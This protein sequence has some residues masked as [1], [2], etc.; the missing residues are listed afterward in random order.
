M[1]IVLNLPAQLNWVE[2]V[3]SG[4]L[5][6]HYFVNKDLLP[7]GVT[8]LLD[9]LKFIHDNMEYLKD[10]N[11]YKC[12]VSLNQRPWDEVVKD[13]LLFFLLSNN[14]VREAL[15]KYFNVRDDWQK[16][17]NTSQTSQ[18]K[19]EDW[20]RIS[21]ALQKKVKD[22]DEALGQ[23]VTYALQTP[24]IQECLTIVKNIVVDEESAREASI[25]LYDDDLTATMDRH[26][27]TRDTLLEKLQHQLEK[28]E[29]EIIAENLG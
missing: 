27:T 13:N 7:K 22:A 14:A 28:I 29:A 20:N 9:E 23:A 6:W 26:R 17:L 18:M 11:P 16:H 21:D 24:L 25:T 12:F 15:L 1:S 5:K 19:V 10:W 2:G 3:F 4:F 8:E